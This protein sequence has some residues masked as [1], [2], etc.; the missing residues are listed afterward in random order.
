MLLGK[1]NI[2]AHL[3]FLFSVYLWGILFFTLLRIILLI[4][5]LSTDILPFEDYKY[6][7]GSFFYGF[8]FDTSISCYMLSLPFIISSF[9]FIFRPLRK[10]F[11]FISYYLILVF[12]CVAFFICCADIPYFNHFASRI[13][14]AALHWTDT[15][16]F[17]IRMILGTFNFW[18]YLIPFLL[19]CVYFIKAANRAK[20]KVTEKISEK[21]FLFSLK[22]FLFLLILAPLLFL[23]VRG[24]ISAKSPMLTGTAYFCDNNFLNQ[25]GLNAV[26]TFMTS[27]LEDMRPENQRL[28]LMDDETAVK[29]VKKYLNS[30]NGFNSPVARKII[31]E[32]EARKMNIVLVIME[33]MSRF[34]MGALGGPTHVTPNLDSLKKRSL[35]FE[36]I[37][38]QGIHTFNG[39]YSSLYSYP[40]LV[41]KHPMENIPS[42]KFY[43]MP[44]VFKEHD[45]QTLFFI[46]HDGQFDNA[47]GFL[48][49]NGIDRVYAENDYPSEKALSTLGIPDDYLFEYSIPKLNEIADQNQNFFCG[50]MTGSNHFPIIF[51]EWADI[52]FNSTE[53]YLK[54]IEYADWAIGKFM[55]LASEQRWYKNT[56]FVF[57]ADHGTNYLHTYD[58]PMAFHFSP[59]IIHAPGLRLE[60][61]SFDGMGG[62]IDI[63]PTLMGLMNLPYTNNTM[64]V[65]LLKEKR[66]Y[67][68]FTADNKIGCIDKEFY[69]IHR[70]NGTE[71]LYKYADLAQ[72]NY[73]SQ[74]KTRADSMRTYAFSM[75]Q[76]TQCIIEKENFSE[77]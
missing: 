76:A 42:K 40:S 38:T 9:G 55:K 8:R 59:L 70:M 26:F 34:N 5:N 74:F 37:Y 2:P 41:N 12:Y 21:T 63:F 36:N 72:D 7:A 64:G 67:I 58:M 45:Y 30:G 73:L 35:W 53:E 28:N 48:T 50:F 22:S 20:K 56:I 62:Q 17:M 69:F 77:K 3:R 71:S 61:K 54:I 27:L 11:F 10:I 66:P 60:P 33:G 13:S 18:I 65:D 32:G 57:V 29:N 75:L 1:I 46:T 43:S 39:I 68:Y 31:A 44:Q 19:L 6:I 52:K 25:L 16:W 24:R 14:R 23:G 47:Q 49:G 4:T 15:P 51:P